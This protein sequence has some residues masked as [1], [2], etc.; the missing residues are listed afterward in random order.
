MGI[1]LM[2]LIKK[3]L[4]QYNNNMINKKINRKN[5][6]GFTLIEL[7]A[8]IVVLAI[9]MVIATQQ[10][11]KVLKKNAVESF[12]SSLDVVVRQAKMAYT[13]KGDSVTANDIAGMVDY[14]TSQYTISISSEQN[15]SGFVCITSVANGEFGNLDISY[16]DS[17]YNASQK[18]DTTT[19]AIKNTTICKSFK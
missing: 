9:I 8:V 15:I 6:K 17:K 14:D 16:F 19:P 18:D 7:L 11:S 3:F 4:L 5:N 13:Q 10:I 1:R 12:Q 2:R